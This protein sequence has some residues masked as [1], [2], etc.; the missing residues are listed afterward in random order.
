MKRF[1]QFLVDDLQG[2]LARLFGVVAIIIVCSGVALSGDIQSDDA[3]AKAYQL[4]LDGKVDE[5]KTLLNKHLAENPKDAEA[6][7]E[8]AR[9]DGYMT[10]SGR[11]GM[12]AMKKSLDDASK[13]IQKAVEIEPDNVIYRYYAAKVTFLESYI[14]LQSGQGDGKELVG[15]ICRAFEEVLK[16]KPDYGEVM[17]NLVEMYGGLPEEMGTD[18]AKAEQYT[19]RLEKLDPILGTKARAIMLPEGAD[20]IGYW[21]EVL[22]K[23]EGKAAVLEALGKQY[24]RQEKTEE[25]EQYIEKAL[26]ADPA[27]TD[28][29]LDM[30]RY[31]VYRMM[32]DEKLKDVE[33]PVTEEYVT[34]YLATGPIAPLQAYAMGM[35]ARLKFISG[36]ETEGKE[37]KAKAEAIDPYF[38]MASGIPN[39]ELFVPLG[40]IPHNH[41][42]L[43]QP[44]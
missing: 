10:I 29:L 20:A 4:R 40:R 28:L 25:G 37:L 32:G 43:F 22:K 33:V 34:R 26:K 5:A 11:G 18:K 36:K 35:L 15:D 14:A 44:F 16:L 39:P 21:Q 1:T 17:L 19:A 3:V 7:Y 12:E 13:A 31:H 30:A 41:T 9:L 23:H 38:S 42:Y 2:L 24:L 27:R 8:L 6:Y